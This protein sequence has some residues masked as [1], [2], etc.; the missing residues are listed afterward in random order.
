[1]KF[2]EP[3]RYRGREPWTTNPGDPYGLFVI[4]PK[5]RSWAPAGLKIIASDGFAGDVD[6]HWEH[7]SVTHID[8]RECPTWTE[9]DAVKHLF[10]DDQECVVQ[11]HPAESVK[12][13]QHPGC[14][15]LWR[16]KLGSFPTPP[17]DCV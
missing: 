17:L 3:L 15:H 4:L 6:T 10:W 14:L 16:F 9:M 11:F 13:N 2:P 12:R 1:M 8:D 7:A 5:Q